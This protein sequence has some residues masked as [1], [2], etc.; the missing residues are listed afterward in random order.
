M[1]YGLLKKGYEQS[2]YDKETFFYSGYKIAFM[3]LWSTLNDIQAYRYN[4]TFSSSHIKWTLISDGSDYIDYRTTSPSF[5]TKKQANSLKMRIAL[6]IGFIITKMAPASEVQLQT[7]LTRLNTTRNKLYL[8]HGDDDDSANFFSLTEEAKD[9][10]T[11]ITPQGDIL[12][13]FNVVSYLL[14][15]D[16]SFRFTL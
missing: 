10:S 2:S 9:T 6:Q 12:D 7:D 8:T 16:E 5:H 11:T 1:F 13:L 3:T 4:K 14:S 15:G